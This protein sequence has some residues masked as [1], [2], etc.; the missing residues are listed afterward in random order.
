MGSSNEPEQ[1]EAK[2]AA[3]PSRA[4]TGVDLSPPPRRRSRVWPILRT[5]L[6]VGMVLGLLG[7]FVG[8]LYFLYKRAKGDPPAIKT[9]H[10]FRTEIVKKAVATGSIVPRREILIKP[11]VSGILKKLYVEPGNIVHEG[12]AIADVQIIPDVVALT[13]AES[14]VRSADIAMK[15]AEMELRRAERLSDQGVLANR[16][17]E[18]KRLD[19]EL[20]KSEMGA[21]QNNLVVVRDGAIARTGAV[22]HT[23]ILA[24]VSGMVLDVPVLE[25]SSVIESN[26]FNEG[27]TVASVADMSDMIFDGKV[28]EA[29]VG[30]IHP[31]LDVSIQIGAIENRTFDANLEYIAAKGKLVDG[32]IQFEVK[33]ALK[34]VADVVVRAGYSAN[35]GIVLDRK[36]DVLALNEKLVQFEGEKPFVEVVKGPG[37]LERRDVTLGISDGMKIEVTGGVDE[38]DEIKQPTLGPQPKN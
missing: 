2:D 24:T 5:I 9:E 33:A 6:V 30:K 37:K 7:G 31:G 27:T 16:D 23:K 18:D 15:H 8:T 4:K 13:R 3:A 21:S 25:G 17:L 1:S 14:D 38:S 10:P 28:D 32:A 36:T 11:R 26:S 19:F 35:A 29:D 20:K 12:D 22:S 34:P